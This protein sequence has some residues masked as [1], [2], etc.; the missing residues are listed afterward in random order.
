MAMADKGKCEC[1]VCGHANVSDF[2]TAYV[3]IDGEWEPKRLAYCHECDIE[4][5]V[6][7]A[8]AVSSI[9]GRERREE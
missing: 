8:E 9:V 5:E 4:F 1:P 6:G 3:N 7:L 2:G